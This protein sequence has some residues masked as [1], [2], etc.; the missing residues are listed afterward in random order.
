MFHLR[1][2]DTVEALSQSIC[3]DIRFVYYNRRNMNTP[4]KGNGRISCRESEYC[5]YQRTLVTY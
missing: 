2:S 4:A 3:R 1:I 5:D